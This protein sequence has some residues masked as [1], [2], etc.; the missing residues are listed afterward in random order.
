MARTSIFVPKKQSIT[1]SGEFTIGWHFM[2]NEVFNNTGHLVSSWND[3]DNFL[4]IMLFSGLT[5]FLKKEKKTQL[6]Y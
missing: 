1:S 4:N 6:K 3:S 5:A 2:L